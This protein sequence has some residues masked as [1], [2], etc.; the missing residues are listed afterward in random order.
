[1]WLATMPGY[2]VPQQENGHIRDGVQHLLQ[3]VCGGSCIHLL[4]AH[5]NLGTGTQVKSAEEVS[6]FPTWVYLYD[7]RLAFGHPDPLAGGLQ[8]QAS[9]IFSQNGCLR[10]LLDDIDQFFSISSSNSATAVS[11]RER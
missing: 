7:W 5:G 1:M 10:R 11:D 8:V 9:L 2:L 3:V 6:T 4:C